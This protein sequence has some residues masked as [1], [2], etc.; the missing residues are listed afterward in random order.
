MNSFRSVSIVVPAYNE[1]DC[2]ADCLYALQ[3]QTYHGTYEIIVVDN[4]STDHTREIAQSMGVKVIKEPRKGYVYAMR[5]GFAAA[6]GEIIA[7]TDA[8][9]IVS[10]SWLEQI[11][12]ALQVDSNIVAT[13]GVFQVHH[14]SPWLA[15]FLSLASRFIG[16]PCGGNMAVRK[17]AYDAVGGFHPKIN[18]GTDTDLVNRMKHIGRVTVDK[19]IIVTT[20]G[21]RYQFA[22]WQNI[23]KYPLNDFWVR[24][25]H[26]PLF[27]NFSDIRE[28]GRQRLS[29]GWLATLPILIFVL[30]FFGYQAE[31]PKSELLGPVLASEKVVQ[32]VIAITFDDGPSQYT[33]QVLDILKRYHVK[34]TF[35]LIGKNIERHPDIP[36]RIAADGHTIGNHTYSHS[37]WTS[38]DF[39]KKIDFEL[40]KT[41]SLIQATAHV[42]PILFR[43]PRGLRNPWMIRAAEKRGYT[44]IMWSI[45]ANDWDNPRPS[46]QVI[47]QR[48]LS[49][50]KPGSIILLH[51]GMGTS[52]N[53]QVQNMVAALPIIIETLQAKGYSFVTIPE[54]MQI[55]KLSSENNPLMVPNPSMYYS[56]NLLQHLFS[57]R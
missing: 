45:Q 47:A 35:F 51:D 23:W 10:S 1:D 11:V 50:I 20:S 5:T 4:A 41:S 42:T 28:T 6:T 57:A 29:R 44:V 36:A 33:P 46:P 13:G 21:R 49:Q 7:S 56:T 22:F 25:W 34:A 52:V 18:M 39:P 30:T 3:N 17:W 40:D 16:H 15:H 54:L 48:V 37:W 8:D 31:I 24:L 26:R 19:S 32:P 38:I 27:F 43:P 14:C 55:K 12:L 53:P 9:S 2:L